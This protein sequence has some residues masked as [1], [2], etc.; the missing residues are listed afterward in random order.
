[1]DTETK[2]EN[3]VL[4]VE[5]EALIGQESVILNIDGNIVYIIPPGSS[6]LK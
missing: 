1:M 5:S 3:E 2:K 4:V 6:L